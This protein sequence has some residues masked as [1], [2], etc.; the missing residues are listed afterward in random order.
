[1]SEPTTQDVNRG[2]VIPSKGRGKSPQP[3]QA[4]RPRMVVVETVY[5]QVPGESPTSNET[6]FARQL[7]TG[8]QPYLR[9]GKAGMNWTPLDT[10]W[11]QVA[12]SLCLRNEEGRNLTRVPTEEQKLALSRK[13]LLLGV[14]DGDGGVVAFGEVLPG[15]SLRM[16]PVSLSQLFLRTLTDAEEGCRYTLSL[17]PE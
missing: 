3:P 5:Y 8:E 15:E 11:I 12:S 4:P 2:V 17:L 16:T 13:V 14:G 6:R 1:M 9:R 7:N 10:G